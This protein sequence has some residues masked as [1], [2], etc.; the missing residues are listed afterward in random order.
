MS[1][2]TLCA[3]TLIVSFGFLAFTVLYRWSSNENRRIERE[4]ADDIKRIESEIKKLEIAID[5]HDDYIDDT[6]GVIN[7][8]HIDLAVQD[9]SMATIEADI[10]EIKA[11]IKI[12]LKRE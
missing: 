3:I 4:E 8:I 1:I 7:Q 11:D 10:A 2:Y 6:T 12:L 5:E 9:R